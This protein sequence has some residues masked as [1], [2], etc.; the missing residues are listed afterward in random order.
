MAAEAWV[1]GLAL[2]LDLTLGELPRWVHPVV[3]M[4]WA[5]GLGERILGGGAAGRGG[6]WRQLLAGLVLA[7]VVPLGSALAAQ[8][9]VAQLSGE[10]LVGWVVGGLLLSATF[11]LRGL[12]RAAFVV[13]DALRHGDLGG[14]RAGLR[15]LCSRDPSSLD[16]QQLVGS[17]IES[18]AE[19]ASDSFVAPLFYYVLGGIPGAVFYRA[20]NTL[21]AMIGYRGRYEYLGKASARLDD[22]LNLIPARLTAGCLL[23]AGVLCRRSPRNAL[24]ILRRDGGKTA[25]PNA[26][27]PMATMAGLLAVRLEK[28]TQYAL[29]DPA[30]GLAVDKIGDA[31]RLVLCAAGAAFAVAVA[32]LGVGH[33]GF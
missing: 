3:W 21:D 9:L 27:W 25:S 17:T 15:S 31:W 18:L 20:V 7:L 22:L 4:G 24:A 32:A 13:R 23:L 5:I 1:L 11:S 14:A 19:N 33:G 10:G 30:E 16:A 2:A 12:G 6:A 28:G 29:G 26:G 8:L